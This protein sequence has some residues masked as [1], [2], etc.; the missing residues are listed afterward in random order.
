LKIDRTDL[1]RDHNIVEAREHELTM[2]VFAISAGMVGVC[3][4]GIG[5]LR[6]ITNQTRAGTVGDDLLAADAVMFMICSILS[7]WSFK[8]AHDRRRRIIRWIID[9]LF[10]MAL[11]LMVAVCALIVYTLG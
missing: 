11:T 8:T 5:L 6:V 3:L 4:T 7:F 1:P 2:H 10:L 9:A